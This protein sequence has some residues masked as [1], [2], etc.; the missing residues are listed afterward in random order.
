MGKK[1]SKQQEARS[2]PIKNHC[3][4]VLSKSEDQAVKQSESPD[5][6]LKRTLIIAK[7]EIEKLS[8][9]NERQALH[10]SG[11]D[12]AVRLLNAGQ[13]G[14]AVGRDSSSD[15]VWCLNRQ[16]EIVDQ[17]AQARK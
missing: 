8:K 17:Q 15:A 6:E 13:G 12:D 10:L 5:S 2:K 7:I 9:V 14:F 1:N 11:F 4:A 3:A 16:I